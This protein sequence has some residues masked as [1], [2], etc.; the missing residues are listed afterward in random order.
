M[1]PRVHRDANFPP[2]LP[3]S[4]WA[5]LYHPNITLT[6][7]KVIFIL[8]IQKTSLNFFFSLVKYFYFQSDNTNFLF[9]N[10]WFLLLKFIIL[11]LKYFYIYFSAFKFIHL[12]WEDS[13][14]KESHPTPLYPLLQRVTLLLVVVAKASFAGPF[15]PTLYH[16]F[17]FIFF[18]LLF[19]ACPHKQIGMLA[20][21][22]SSTDR[23]SV[24]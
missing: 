15:P 12:I 7:S 13:S 18:S 1:A 21:S 4:M 23:K 9:Y 5:V 8:S 24:V 19:S 22:L 11:I 3:K 2:T 14:S 10:S 20:E 17:V 16:N 6:P